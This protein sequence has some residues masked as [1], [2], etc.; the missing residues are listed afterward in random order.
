MSKKPAS[1]QGQGGRWMVFREPSLNLEAEGISQVQTLHCGHCQPSA[2][3]F[4]AQG[5]CRPSATSAFVRGC[6][7]QG[8]WLSRK[9]SPRQWVG[10]GI[11][12]APLTSQPAWGS[13]VGLGVGLRGA[14]G[15]ERWAQA[16]LGE[17]Y[18]TR[19][20]SLCCRLCRHRCA[21]DTRD[22][23]QQREEIRYSSVFLSVLMGFS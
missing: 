9:Q 4:T 21:C 5:Q 14:V 6:R 8:G 3:W 19:C 16:E 23:L 13:S 7:D 20:C 2:G 1:R 10:N 11:W 12:V 17:D 15:Q 22:Y 18:N